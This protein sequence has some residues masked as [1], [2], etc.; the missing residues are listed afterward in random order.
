MRHYA[1]THSPLKL[2]CSDLLVLLGSPSVASTVL[3]W[4]SLAGVHDAHS[5]YRWQ[6]S[7][8]EMDH[9]TALSD[10]YTYLSCDLLLMPSGVDTHTHT[11]T[12]T[13][14]TISKNQACAGLRP[15]HA[16]FK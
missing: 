4:S 13:D 7:Y 2:K 3:P 15:A 9:K 14:K 6:E 1:F 10:Y 11:P 5:I 12:F 16:W 8:K